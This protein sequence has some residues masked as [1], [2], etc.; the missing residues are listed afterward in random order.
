[1]TFIIGLATLVVSALLPIGAARFA[2]GL[3]LT[4]VNPQRGR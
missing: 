1:M 2:L 3:L 4:V